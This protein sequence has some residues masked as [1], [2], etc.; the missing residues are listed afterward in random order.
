MNRDPITTILTVA[1][2]L[3]VL[4]TAGICYW[5]LQSMRQLYTA[6]AHFQRVTRDR[7]LMQ[8]FATQAMEYGKQNPAILPILESVGIRRGSQMNAATNS[9]AE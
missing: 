2:L 1:L 5:Y 8:Q 9:S 4:A 7:A 6:Q 3:S